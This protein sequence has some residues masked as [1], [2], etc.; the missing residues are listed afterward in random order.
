MATTEMTLKSTTSEVKEV[1]T[2]LQSLEIELQSQ[3]SMVRTQC[4]LIIMLTLLAC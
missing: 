4:Y 2:Q 1:K 3:M